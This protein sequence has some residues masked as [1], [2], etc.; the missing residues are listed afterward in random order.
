MILTCLTVHRNDIAESKRLDFR[1]SVPAV[2]ETVD[3]GILLS[4]VVV[5]GEISHP[6]TCIF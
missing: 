6:S 5:G 2:G 4:L 3:A 1:A